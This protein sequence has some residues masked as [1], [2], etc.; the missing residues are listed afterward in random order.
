[1]ISLGSVIVVAVQ[2]ARDEVHVAVVGNLRHVEASVRGQLRR[3]HSIT[4]PRN[5]FPRFVE[6]IRETHTRRDRVVDDHAVLS[7]RGQRRKQ[8][9][10]RVGRHRG[11]FVVG[12]L[13]V[14]AHAHVQRQ[15]AEADLIPGE[16]APVHAVARKGPVTHDGGVHVRVFRVGR[17]ESPGESALR[18]DRRLPPSES[19]LQLVLAFEVV[20]FE[21]QVALRTIGLVPGIGVLEDA[22]VVL[23]PLRVAA[24]NR[25]EGEPAARVRVAHGQERRVRH[26]V[27]H[28]ALEQIGRTLLV[29]GRRGRAIGRRVPAEL[30]L[31]AAEIGEARA[32]LV[33]EHG[34]R[35]GGVVLERRAV[36]RRQHVRFG[37]RRV[38]AEPGAVVFAL[39]ADG[40]LGRVVGVH[41]HLGI[42]LAVGAPDKQLVLHDRSAA[43][44]AVVGVLVKA[45]VALQPAHRVFR[46]VVR[47]QTVVLEVV[48]ARP[49]PAVR[50]GAQHEVELHARRRVGRIGAARD[51]LHLLEHVEVVVG[52]CRPHGRHVRDGNAVHAPRV[53]VV[54]RALG[55]VRRLLPGFGAANVHAVD[56]DPRHRLQ[57]D[58]RVARGRDAL[59]LVER[60]V[61]R[62]RLLLGLDDRRL[63]KDVHLFGDRPD[64]ERDRQVDDGA[65]AN[66]HVVILVV[67]EAR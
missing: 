67:V 42:R 66:R 50:A 22:G 1:M 44:H 54:A 34:G 65:G 59:Q 57:H 14:P 32:Q 5:R 51:D 7:G 30:D 62:H 27:V 4:R 41:L 47:L 11:G 33:R 56:D 48:A 17:V 25:L 18:R 35:L 36:A 61:R 64:R 21:L 6:G 53:V 13:T 8:I 43:F 10:E 20:P 28:L 60:H 55:L 31:V 26:R 2:I 3:K 9:R 23:V 52:R 29:P 63:G 24:A 38:G 39:H 58:P 40:T 46:Q 37:R 49:T 12:H 45:V 16:R 15:P 19:E